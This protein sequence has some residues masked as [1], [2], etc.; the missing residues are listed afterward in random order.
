M[1]RRPGP[2]P[3]MLFAWWFSLQESLR[4]QINWLCCS[5]CGIP[6]PYLKGSSLLCLALG[7]Y[8]LVDIFSTLRLEFDS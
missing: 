7:S 2:N 1:D 3:C 6:I 4:V 5:S 8:W